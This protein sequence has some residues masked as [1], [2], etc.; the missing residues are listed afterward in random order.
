MS[1]FVAISQLC[2]ALAPFFIFFQSRDE[3]FR[4]I[5][6]SFQ[7]IVISLRRDELFETVYHE[8]Y[9]FDSDSNVI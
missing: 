8:N 9:L 2:V 7:I 1:G 5:V 3:I 4:L 6:L